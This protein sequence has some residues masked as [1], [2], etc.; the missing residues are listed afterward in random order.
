MRRPEEATRIRAKSGPG[1]LRRWARPAP[2]S[3][4][5]LRYSP[6]ADHV[7]DLESWRPLVTGPPASGIRADFRSCMLA[8][9]GR[10]RRRAGCSEPA[11]RP[12]W[13]ALQPV[14]G[15]PPP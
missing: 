3:D 7:A 1:L 15:H 10:A 11:V 14:V 8:W 12:G 9:H 4:Q 6:D 2:P 5:A 13:P